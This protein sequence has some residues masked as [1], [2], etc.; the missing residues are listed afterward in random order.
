MSPLCT[1]PKR[2]ENQPTNCQV[3]KT[4]GANVCLRRLLA[5]SGL[6]CKHLSEFM[7]A[8]WLLSALLSWTPVLNFSS[9]QPSPPAASQ[10]YRTLPS[11]PHG[12]LVLLCLPLPC[13]SHVLSSSST[14][15]PRPV[16]WPRSVH[17]FLSLLWTLPPDAS[18]CILLLSMIK[19][20]PHHL[21]GVLS[22]LYTV[23]AVNTEPRNTN[24][25]RCLQG[26]QP[27]Q[28]LFIGSGLWEGMQEEPV[29]VD[30]GRGVWLTHR[31][32]TSAPE[33]IRNKP[34][35]LPS[36]LGA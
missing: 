22:S 17:Y 9:V 11:R 15:Q 3:Q 24:Q 25:K 36:L 33:G 13:P 20:S 16:R 23:R 30:P 4:L 12:L 32:H 2:K 19:T 14:P 27:W 28:S 31:A 35:C 7:R 18:G 1:N 34:V 5:H 8:S 26:G 29:L 10:P 21:G 6:H